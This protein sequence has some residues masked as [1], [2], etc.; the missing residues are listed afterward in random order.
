M[1]D[2]VDPGD[3]RRDP[4][5]LA[6]LAAAGALLGH[7]LGYLADPSAGSGHEYLTI[8]GPAVATAAV[9]AVWSLAVRVLR[10]GGGALP[11]VATLAAGQSVLYLGFEIGER[12]IGS[13]E[14]PL[15]SSAVVLGLVAQPLVAWLGL[16][17]LAL[18]HQVLTAIVARHRRRAHPTRSARWVRI[19]GI[20]A[21]TLLAVS[22][23]GRGPPS[24]V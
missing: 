5:G 13:A 6:A 17:F 19:A 4:F 9:V 16:R 12:T 15:W 18:G 21:P 11:S 22:H 20:P 7:E 24:I 8:V 14:S 2:S 3:S 1:P 23:P 10:R